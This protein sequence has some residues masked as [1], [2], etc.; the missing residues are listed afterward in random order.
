MEVITLRETHP[1]ALFGTFLRVRGSW[2][3][4]FGLQAAAAEALWR[5]LTADVDQI[6]LCWHIALVVVEI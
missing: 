6:T 4:L 2:D 1:P 3:F 5:K